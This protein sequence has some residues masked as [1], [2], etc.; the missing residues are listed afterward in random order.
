MPLLLLT[1]QGCGD[2]KDTTSA[3]SS[4]K[5][6][7]STPYGYVASF[8]ERSQ[9][10]LGFATVDGTCWAQPVPGEIWW[11]A[12]RNNQ[13]MDFDYLGQKSPGMPF[14]RVKDLDEACPAGTLATNM[15]EEFV[16]DWEQEFELFQK[17]FRS[18]YAFFTLRDVDWDEQVKSARK[19]IDANMSVEAFF[20]V[21]SEAVAPLGDGHIVIQAGDD[22]VFNASTRP[23]IYASLSQE[24]QD[25]AP[26]DE[27]DLDS[28]VANY[29]SEQVSKLEDAIEKKLVDGSE[30][31]KFTDPMFWA[32][33]Q[34]EG[35]EYAYVRLTSFSELVPSEDFPV[36]SDNIEALHRF[37]GEVLQSP[38]SQ[39]GLV[40]D[41]RINDGGW[42]HLGRE[43]VSRFVDRETHVYS[44]RVYSN[45][46]FGEKIKLTVSPHSD[47]H[48]SRPIVVL[49]SPSTI[50]AAET[51]VMAMSELKQVR[52]IGE[53]T[54]GITSD[55]TPKFLPSGIY[56]SLSNEE[57]SSPGGQVFELRGV[58]P[59]V[60]VPVFTEADRSQGKDSALVRALEDLA[61]R[62]SR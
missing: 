49:T 54:H 19:K 37:M 61:T 11:A 12:P 43:L 16:P 5:V 44:K 17:T 33:I 57:Y 18:Q 9:E 2:G 13:R 8:N 14:I 27:E 26:S 28:Y 56:F 21:L 41:V 55:A 42:D 34:H 20:D 46:T 51:F 29:V 23:D 10:A 25:K 31:G 48:Y 52:T 22:L 35:E 62:A 7:L 15:D 39:H 58:E 1:P 45:E 6:Y 36:V 38:S 30:H 24:A 32:R 60:Q 53:T 4:T 3:E 50:S 40:I 59:D 47:E